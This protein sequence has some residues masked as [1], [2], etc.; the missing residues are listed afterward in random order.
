LE[1]IDV[2]IHITAITLCLALFCCA[3]M[4]QAD[5]LT[6]EY[7]D[8]SFNVA[9]QFSTGTSGFHGD[10]N[11]DGDEEF[12]TA[13]MAYDL[14]EM[15]ATFPIHIYDK[16]GKDITNE[17]LAEEMRVQFVKR[18][19]FA[20]F[21][22]DGKTDMY[23]IASGWEAESL[24]SGD[25][26]NLVGEED[27]LWL[28][29][30]DGKL[31]K[32]YEPGGKVFHH[33]GDCADIDNDGD[34]D[35]F[36]CVF[37]TPQS[38]TA[39]AYFLI[40]DGK[41][42]FTLDGVDNRIQKPEGYWTNGQYSATFADVNNDGNVDIILGRS[43]YG[44]QNPF[45]KNPIVV[46]GNGTGHFANVIKLPWAKH[47]GESYQCTNHISVFD[48]N[49]DGYVDIIITGEYDDSDEQPPFGGYVQFLKN[50][51]GTSFTDVTTEFDVDNI[52]DWTSRKIDIIDYDN[53]GFK[54]IVIAGLIPVW[55]NHPDFVAPPFPDN[56]Y[57][58]KNDNYAYTKISAKEFFGDRHSD[59]GMGTLLAMS[60]D[61]AK[62]ATVANAADYS[63]IFFHMFSYKAPLP[64]GGASGGGGG[65]CNMG[66]HA[67]MAL[68]ILPIV[69]LKRLF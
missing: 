11:N 61:K 68:L 38:P 30:A 62:F 4:A 33:E 13:E 39:T 37:G 29:G 25:A 23:T 48:F 10:I 52:I 20:D 64:T 56:G 46:L 42:N 58:F 31:H 28:S 1:E 21:N 59:F 26:T 7:Q 54:D 3:S 16:N 40:N 55:Q 27:Q 12:V 66:S 2:K 57:I 24:V 6:S 53:N 41:G 45:S 63:G 17:I 8:Y 43:G 49:N 65:G 67:I 14:D 22:G 18:I 34:I 51:N 32:A 69:M 5:V 36:V 19:L 44:E 60:N 50:N 35:I 47:V 9:S 15:N